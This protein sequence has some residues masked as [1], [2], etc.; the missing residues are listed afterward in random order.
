MLFSEV[1]GTYYHI[2]SLLLEQAVEGTLT[3]ILRQFP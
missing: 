2:L 1:Y 3:G